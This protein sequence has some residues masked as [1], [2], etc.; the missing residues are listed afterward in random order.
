MSASKTV[1]IFFSSGAFGDCARHAILHAMDSEQISKIK[2]Y[3]SK[4]NMPSLDD[5]NWKCGCEV[6]HGAEMKKSPNFSKIEM[7][8]IDVTNKD[9]MESKLDLVGVDA[10]ISGLGN[11]QIFHGDRVGRKGTRNVGKA[12]AKA[13]IDRIVAMSS[14]GVNEDKPCMEWR[15]EGKFM[16][17][18]FNTV[19]RREYK[20]IAGMENDVRATD[21][22][23][24]LVRPVGL[25]EGCVPRG[26]YFIQKKKFEDALGPNM[27]KSDVGR[28]LLDQV[29]TPTYEKSAVVIGADPKEAYD[30]FERA[31]MASNEGEEKETTKK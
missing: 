26:E 6:D 1:A 11:R 29:L 2:V 18:L 31:G 30:S 19:S 25:G 23:Y 27:A 28:F 24:L 10:V 12:M 16:A 3:A 22:N 14:M 17:A 9:E 7:I 8:T 13:N 5:A 15:T 20:D 21:L 4:K